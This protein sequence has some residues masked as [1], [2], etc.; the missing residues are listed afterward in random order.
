M[1]KI[2]LSRRNLESLLNKLDRNIDS[3]G[4]SQCT[5]LVPNDDCTDYAAEIHAVE[6]EVKYGSRIVPPGPVH[7]ADDFTR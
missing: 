4:A 3:P 7:P 6:N 5:L 2:V 1:V